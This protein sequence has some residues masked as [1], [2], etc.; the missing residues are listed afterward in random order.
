[1]VGIL[2]VLLAFFCAACLNSLGKVLSAEVS[3]GVLLFIQN[4]FALCFYSPM[5]FSTSLKTQK[6]RWHVLRAVTGLL[7]YACLFFAIKHISL[8]NATLLANSAPLFLPFVIFVWFRE[9][10]S[11]RLWW[12][13]IIGF[14][15]VFFIIN[16]TANIS[17][18]FKSWIVL[19][20]L[21]GSL[22]SAIA[23]QTI[24]YLSKTEKNQTINLYYFG[25]ST[26]CTLPFLWGQGAFFENVNWWVCIGAG[27]FLAFTQFFLAEAYRRESPTLLGPFNY[28]VV[29]FIG[30]LGWIFWKEI[31]G[32]MDIIGVLL[33]CFGGILS[34]KYLR[35]KNG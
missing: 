11:A 2:F 3:L 22:F 15:G 25:L 14:V 23:L 26:L 21:L 24:Q 29:I 9:K 19:I 35:R 34:L 13:L 28:S 12:S 16:P 4:F 6:F 18:L 20:A 32:I 30:L 8:L 17:S 1:M 5:L 33:I 10:I 31:P 7:S 27:F